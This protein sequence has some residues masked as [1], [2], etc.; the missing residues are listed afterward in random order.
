MN[1]RTEDHAPTLALHHPPVPH[2][3]TNNAPDFWTSHIFWLANTQK[4]FK[5]F[6]PQQT[7]SSIKKALL[8]QKAILGMFTRVDSIMIW[9]YSILNLLSAARRSSL[10]HR[11][12][13]EQPEG[14]FTIWAPPFAISSAPLCLLKKVKVCLFSPDC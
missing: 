12:L 5:P 14:L 1:K 4:A 2:T 11:M 9:L 10:N 7:G 3:S 6:S 8:L 13:T